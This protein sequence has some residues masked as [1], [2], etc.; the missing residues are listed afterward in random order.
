MDNNS[1]IMN[2]MDE[3]MFVQV[4]LCCLLIRRVTENRQWIGQ[5][6]GCVK[7]TSLRGPSACPADLAWNKHTHTL[8]HAHTLT[9]L[10]L[11]HI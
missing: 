2:G 3:T 1:K 5:T 9:P 7:P 4:L 11:I 6:G 10:S 8:T